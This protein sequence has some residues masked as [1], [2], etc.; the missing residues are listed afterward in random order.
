[1]EAIKNFLTKPVSVFQYWMFFA[2]GIAAVLIVIVL[3]SSSKNSKKNASVSNGEDTSPPAE[4]PCTADEACRQY[5]EVLRGAGDINADESANCLDLSP[6]AKADITQ[7]LPQAKEETQTKADTETETPVKAE[8]QT[9]PV[10]AEETEVINGQFTDAEPK[11]GAPEETAA[12][13]SDSLPDSEPELNISAE[14]EDE[15]EDGD[16]DAVVAGES[17]GVS[18]KFIICRSNAEGFR[19][20]L[21]ANNGQ[22]LYESRDYKSTVTCADAS[23]KFCLA[24]A[25]G[26][27]SV[28][29]DKFDRFKFY[30]RPQ[31]NANTVYIG[32][33]FKT[34]A[35]CLSNIESVKRFALVS[36]PIV[37]RSDEACNCAAG[38]Y[39]ISE[40]LRLRVANNE[41][42][43]GKW[44]IANADEEDPSSPF[45]YLLYANNGQLLYESKEYKTYA[46][47]K[48]G[49]ETFIDTVQ[50]GTFIVDADKA[51]RFKFMLRSNKTGSQAEYVGQFYR[52]ADACRRNIESVFK[53]A[54]LSPLDTLND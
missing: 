40:D 17:N 34:R 19:Y 45:E 29:R 11:A 49:L 10:A 41:G 46:T 25:N 43:P 32:E 27:F 16:E 50:N 8:T 33:S 51:G 42:V 1:M 9:E 20:S 26:E 44:R 4:Q 18:G 5:F 52:N 36:A 47:C 3:I 38:K 31:N 22:L 14:D 2:A 35:R 21:L 48:R 6:A 39:E 13:V 23:A 28:K 53:F 30:L 12:T 24:V 54:L 37:D 7:T 15:D